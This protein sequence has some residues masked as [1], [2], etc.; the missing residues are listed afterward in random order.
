ML[1]LSCAF[2]GAVVV[3]ELVDFTAAIPSRIAAFLWVVWTLFAM[4]LAVKTYLAPNCG[5]YLLRHWM[6]ALTVLVPF[7]RPLR[8]LRVVAVAIRLWDEFRTTL[9][10]HTFS[11]VGIGS[12]LSVTAAALAMYGLERHGQ[13]PILAIEDAVW[14]ALATITTIG[15][16]D[17]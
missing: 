9:R 6:D 2:L 4:E 7:L 11:L 3:P 15:Y 8:L 1:A 16:G 5:K 14:W 17:V 13:G 12:V 10:D